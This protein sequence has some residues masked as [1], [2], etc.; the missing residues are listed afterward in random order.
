MEDYRG[1]L[2]YHLTIEQFNQCLRLGFNWQGIVSFFGISRRTVFRHRQRLGVGPVLR[3]Q[4]FCVRISICLWFSVCGGVYF[5]LG[6]SSWAGW[7][8]LQWL[9]GQSP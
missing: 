1:R 3:P 5:P 6:L 7:R 9:I 2:R 8:Q 4:W